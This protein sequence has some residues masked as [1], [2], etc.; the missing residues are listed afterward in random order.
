MW[1]LLLIANAIH[2][3]AVDICTSCISSVRNIQPMTRIT[4]WQAES[5]DKDAKILV[6]L[7]C[8]LLMIDPAFV[9]YISA[10]YARALSITERSYLN[11]ALAQS[12]T[13]N[14]PPPPPPHPKKRATHTKGK[15]AN[16]MHAQN[17]TI[18]FCWWQLSDLFLLSRCE[19]CHGQAERLLDSAKEMEDSIAVNLRFLLWLAYL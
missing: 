3:Q 2:V 16:H 10:P 17:P 14:Q 8:F 7:W 18:L 5:L 9:Q 4:N 12:P 1:C 6:S 13:P 11:N 19:S 15:K